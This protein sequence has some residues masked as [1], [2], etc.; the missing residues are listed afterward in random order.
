MAVEAF[1][2][3]LSLEHDNPPWPHR[4]PPP[5][6]QTESPLSANMSETLTPE[7]FNVEGGW[8]TR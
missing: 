5:E 8:E 7:E 2:V 3:P 1:G 6:G 4:P